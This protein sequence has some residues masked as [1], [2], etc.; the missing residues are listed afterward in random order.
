MRI[1]T[2]AEAVRPLTWEEIVG[3]GRSQQRAAT[4]PLCRERLDHGDGREHLRW[5][6]DYGRLVVLPDGCAAHRYCAVENPRRDHA[7]LVA[8]TH[9]PAGVRMLQA[10]R[11]AGGP[12]PG[13]PRL[14]L[15]A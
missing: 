7:L 15:A 10:P 13:A 5:L 3:R 14:S 9:E 6:A 2:D 11:D 4:C 1:R 8:H 12:E